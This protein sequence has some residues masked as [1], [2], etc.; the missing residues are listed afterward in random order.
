MTSFDPTG[1]GPQ[2]SVP[3]RSPVATP[4][5]RRVGVLLAAAMLAL[6][7]IALRDT[8]VTLGW[9]RGTRWIDAAVTAADG[10]HDQWWMVPIGAVGILIGGWLVSCACRPARTTAMKLKAASSQWMSPTDV[11]RLASDAAGGVA[12]VLRARSDATRRRVRVT[13]DQG[14]VGVSPDE[15]RAAVVTALGVLRRPPRVTVR[16]KTGRRQ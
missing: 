10:R 6:G 11:A 1:P 16:I 15:V 13:A 9:L 12:G 3:D 7:V 4:T 5:V 14:D 2:P 8:A